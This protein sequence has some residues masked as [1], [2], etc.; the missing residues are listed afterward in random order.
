VF[1]LARISPERDNLASPFPRHSCSPAPP[2]CSFYGCTRVLGERDFT[3]MSCACPCVCLCVCV[4]TGIRRKSYDVLP[5]T[6]PSWFPPWPLRQGE[7]RGGKTTGGG[8]TGRD[9]VMVQG[10]NASLVPRLGSDSRNLAVS[11]NADTASFLSGLISL[12]SLPPS[13]SSGRTKGEWKLSREILYRAR[14]TYR[15]RPCTLN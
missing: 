9:R 11:D 14:V 10:G 8:T 15:N 12:G 6:G 7:R 1:V 5:A 4:C 13:A 2:L 3:P